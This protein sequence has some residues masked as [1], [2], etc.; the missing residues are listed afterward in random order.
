MAPVELDESSPRRRGE[1]KE[2]SHYD[3]RLGRDDLGR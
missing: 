2:N 3:D 1:V